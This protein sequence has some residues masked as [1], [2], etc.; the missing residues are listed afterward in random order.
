MTLC[1]HERASARCPL[2]HIIDST[3]FMARPHSGTA[4]QYQLV[5]TI[6]KER[7]KGGGLTFPGFMS[8][9]G[10]IVRLMVFM[11]SIV[12]SPSSARR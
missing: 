9:R 8:P 5:K 3:F 4:T 1:I 12:P 10:S 6:K 7:G 11:S 2:Y